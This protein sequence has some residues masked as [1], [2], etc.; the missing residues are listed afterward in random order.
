MMRFLGLGGLFPVSKNWYV[1]FFV[2]VVV[3]ENEV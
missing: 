3:V 1:V 2:S